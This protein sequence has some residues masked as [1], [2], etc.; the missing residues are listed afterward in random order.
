[1]QRE[2][3]NVAR[4]ISMA[5]KLEGLFRHASTHATGV[6]IGDRPL[7][8]L[9]PLTETRGLKCQSLSSTAVC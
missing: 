9:V 7:E 5:L 2:D 3:E 1:M 8:Q 4:L 6:V